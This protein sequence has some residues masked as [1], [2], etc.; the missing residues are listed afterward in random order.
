VFCSNASGLDNVELVS[1]LHNAAF[2][3][4]LSKLPNRTRL[5]EIL[6]ATLAGPARDDATLSLV[7]PT[8]LP[9]P[10]TPAATSSATC[11]WS[12]AACKPSWGAL[13]G[14]APRRRHLLRAGRFLASQSGQHPGL[15][16]R[17]S[18][19]TARTCSC[20]PPGPGAP[21]RHEGTGAD[22]LK[23]ADIA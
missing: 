23:D 9:K 12:P 2:Y 13:T 1:H 10:T 16:Q 15:F 11:C 4:Q 20:P 5:V 8:T 21:G 6:D 3:D 22:A 18:A 17:R 7:D 14:G 19:S